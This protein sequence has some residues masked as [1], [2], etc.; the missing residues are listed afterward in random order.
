M[1][2]KPAQARPPLPPRGKTQATPAFAAPV[3]L[4]AILGST[5]VPYLNWAT[6]SMYTSG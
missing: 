2:G 4:K 6:G 3:P 1:A 5:G